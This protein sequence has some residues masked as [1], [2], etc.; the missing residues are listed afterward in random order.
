MAKIADKIVK[1]KYSILKRR[2]NSFYEEQNSRKIGREYLTGTPEMIYYI[3]KSGNLNG[4]ET[5]LLW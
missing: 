3:D 1:E 4:K 2:T 5:M